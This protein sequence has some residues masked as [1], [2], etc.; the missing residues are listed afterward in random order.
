MGRNNPRMTETV[1]ITGAGGFLGSHLTEFYLKN[2]F[3]VIGVDNF[4]TG[5]R[6][7]LELL[8]SMGGDRLLFIEADA[9]LDWNSFSSKIQPTWLKNL[10]YIY[11]F[12]SP[13][14]PPHYQRLGVETMWINSIGLA[15]AIAFADTYGARVIF[16]STSEVYGDPAVSP[17]PE[18]YWGYVNSYGERSCYDESKRFGEAFIYTHNKK[19]RTLHGLVRIF[20]TYGPRMNPNDGRVVINFILQ[21]LSNADLTIYGDGMQTRSFCYVDDLIKAISLYADSNETQPINIGNNREYTMLELAEII[22]RQLN[23]RSNII[24][25]PLPADDPRQRRP[26]LTQAKELLGYSPLVPLEAGV[27]MMAEWLSTQ[28]G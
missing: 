17:Q 15:N 13:A 1:L 24:Y 10:R 3:N 19:H 4:C 8:K 25:R 9:C 2:K 23:S 28:N 27:V 11:H 5:L 7:N 18:K 16:A 21:A 26:D 6:S 20:N 14:S 12:A 22:I